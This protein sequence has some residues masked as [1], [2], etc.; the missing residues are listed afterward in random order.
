VPRD[1]SPLFLVGFMGAGKTTVG[2]ALARLLGWDFLDL[3]DAIEAA[4]GRSIARIFQ[5]SG[6]PHFRDRER[7]LLA[8]LEGRRRLVVACGG[9]T[10]AHPPA[11]QVIDR[12]GVAVWVEAP[13]G[14]C[15]R[16]AA[17]GPPRPLLKGPRQAEALYRARLP[18]YRTAP[19]RI[20]AERLTPEAAAERIVALL[21]AR[22]A[23]PAGTPD[24][25]SS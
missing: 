17:H 19:L 10:Y 1:E 5:E 11:A 22:A 18:R 24:L 2:Q 20:D 23:G 6:E 7:E 13:L 12:L 15:L 4:E 8:G 16:R 3:D 25:S 14:L 9:G 21:D